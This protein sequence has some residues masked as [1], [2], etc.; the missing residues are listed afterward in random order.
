VLQFGSLVVEGGFCPSSLPSKTLA[1]R[2]VVVF[3]LFSGDRRDDAGNSCRIVRS[4]LPDLPR[5]AGRP[6]PGALSESEWP[7][8]PSPAGHSPL[9][10]EET[11]L[12]ASA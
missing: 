10:P 12:A 11:N 7:A 3:T 8:G 1:N 4:V 9:P 6:R 2:Q 5:R